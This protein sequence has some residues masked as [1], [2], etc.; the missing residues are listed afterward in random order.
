MTG[1]V[2]RI[3][4]DPAAAQADFT[5]AR[6]KQEEL[7][8]ARP[9]NPWLHSGWVR[10]T[11]DLAKQKRHSAKVGKL[12]TYAIAKERL[13]GRSDVLDEFAQ[14]YVLTGERD[15]AVEQ[16]ETLANNPS[17]LDYG[18]LRLDTLWDPLRGDPRFEKIV[19]SLAPR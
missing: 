13:S 1:L 11:L 18:E 16:L 17:Q 4:G 12:G 15:L 8:R 5:A 6:A 2:A 10:L 9:D 19:A 14:I 7:A 3:K